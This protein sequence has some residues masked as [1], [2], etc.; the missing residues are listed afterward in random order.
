MAL[1]TLTQPH[2]HSCEAFGGS[3]SMVGV[4]SDGPERAR[5]QNMV[6]MSEL[7]TGLGATST[8]DFSSGDNILA[9]RVF[10]G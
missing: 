1:N 3:I 9:N 7:L 6:A 5:M 2:D 8:T 10:G 4:P